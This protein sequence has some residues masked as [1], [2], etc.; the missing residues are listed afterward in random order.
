[1]FSALFHGVFCFN[2]NLNYVPTD[3]RKS[4]KKVA[5]GVIT[6][7]TPRLLQGV[8]VAV[9]FN[10]ARRLFAVK[11]CRFRFHDFVDRRKMDASV[12]GD[13]T[14]AGPWVLFQCCLDANKPL[15]IASHL[16]D[17]RHRCCVFRLLG[18]IQQLVCQQFN[19][20]VNLFENLNDTLRICVD[21]RQSVT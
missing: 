11:Q 2:A 1:M 7:V 18:R 6:P 3:R 20:R 17:L 10:M 4:C 19:S 12:P 21:I 8:I 14:L 9:F 16:C 15:C 13:L 5:S